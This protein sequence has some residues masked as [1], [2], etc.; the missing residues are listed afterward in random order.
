MSAFTDKLLRFMSYLIVLILILLA[1]I[2]AYLVYSFLTNP[3]LEN[4]DSQDTPATSIDKDLQQ[5]LNKSN[6]VNL[7]NLPKPETE[8]EAVVAEPAPTSKQ[9]PDQDYYNPFEDDDK[10]VTQPNPSQRPALEKAFDSKPSD[11]SVEEAPKPIDPT[12][13]NQ[14]PDLNA[15]F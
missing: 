2:V 13:K 6:Q 11:E 10:P 5:E 14:Q 12:S 8:N 7:D 4:P 1:C 9:I 3:K 15:L